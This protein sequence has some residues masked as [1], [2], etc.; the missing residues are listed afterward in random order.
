MKK[1]HII[2][3]FAIGTGVCAEID[4]EDTNIKAAAEHAKADFLQEHPRW[5]P[6]SVVADIE[7]SEEISS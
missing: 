2:L 3:L 5:H 7:H 6:L 4:I 1:F